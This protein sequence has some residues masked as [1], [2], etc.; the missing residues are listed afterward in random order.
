MDGKLM[1]KMDDLMS[2]TMEVWMENQEGRTDVV[3]YD[4]TMTN[5]KSGLAKKSSGRGMVTLYGTTM[6]EVV[7]YK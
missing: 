5:L 4:P 3:L 7:N 1:Q 2:E 6:M